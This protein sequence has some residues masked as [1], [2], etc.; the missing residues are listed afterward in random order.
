MARAIARLV[1]P[2]LAAVERPTHRRLSILIFHRV[3][4]SADPLF[5]GEPDAVRVDWILGLVRRAFHVLPLREAVRL[6][7]QGRLPPAALSITFDDS[8]ADNAEVALPLLRRHGLTATFFIASGFLDG[9][10]MFNDSVIEC[11]RR[12]RLEHID[13]TDLG[14]GRLPLNN[15]VERRAAIDALLPRVKYLDLAARETFLQQLQD[16]AGRPALP[17][18]LMM[19][20]SQVVEL[21]RA[22]MDIGGHTVNH[23]I[24]RLLP[25]AQAE[26]EI[27][28]GRDRLQAMTDTAVETFA[29]PNGRP[30]QDYDQRHVD[31]VRR[32]G[33]RA[34][35]S[36]V[37]G[38]AGAGADCFQLPRFTPWDSSPARWLARLTWRRMVSRSTARA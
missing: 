28:D 32:L 26:A 22:G 25:D 2:L 15:V 19:R 9:G 4:R 35:V 13:L 33:F 10:R 5:P 18:D 31:M 21:S 38:V 24:L 37:H 34:A 11:V 23:P 27:R 16:A 6:R 14:L 17:D 29:Y 20:S 1:P 30:G 7:E 8:Y 3:H 36:T 12:S